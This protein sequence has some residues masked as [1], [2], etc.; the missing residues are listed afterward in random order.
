MDTPFPERFLNISALGNYIPAKF[1]TFKESYFHNILIIQCILKKKQNF[2][3]MSE[4]MT[5]KEN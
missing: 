2:L 4:Q 3:K 1:N 5:K